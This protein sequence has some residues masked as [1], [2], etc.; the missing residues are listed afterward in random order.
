MFKCS[1]FKFSSSS[2]FLLLLFYHTFYGENKYFV[3]TFIRLSMCVNVCSTRYGALRTTGCTNT[4][5]K[6]GPTKRPS[7]V[8]GRGGRRYY[9]QGVAALPRRISPENC[10]ADRRREAD[11]GR[12]PVQIPKLPSHASGARAYCTTTMV[13]RHHL[14]NATGCRLPR[15]RRQW[16]W[17]HSDGLCLLPRIVSRRRGP[18]CMP[19]IQ[20]AHGRDARLR[21]VV[22]KRVT[23]SLTSLSSLYFLTAA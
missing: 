14:C 17:G 12:A 10:A 6:C 7:V 2:S 20:K 11:P 19:H 21:A 8:T 1:M 18:L 4:G 5:S 15:T 3:G 22:W 16:P 13:Q 23:S 9:V